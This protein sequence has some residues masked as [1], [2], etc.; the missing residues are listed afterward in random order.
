MPKKDGAIEIEGTV[1]ESLPNAMFRVQLDNGHKVLAHMQSRAC[2]RR[3][4]RCEHA[5]LRRAR[6]QCERALGLRVAAQDAVERQLREED[7]GPEHGDVRIRPR[8]PRGG[9]AV[10][11]EPDAPVRFRHDT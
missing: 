8:R 4:H 1:V 3:I 11:R 7:A 6:H 5:F 9:R 10:E 2:R